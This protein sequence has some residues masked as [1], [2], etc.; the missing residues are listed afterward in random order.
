MARTMEEDV[1]RLARK[2]LDR[3]PADS[4]GEKKACKGGSGQ[5]TKIDLQPTT[6][7]TKMMSG[8]SQLQKTREQSPEEERGEEDHEEGNNQDEGRRDQ[9][10][11]TTGE[12]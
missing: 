4:G 1:K 2:T 3:E 9:N 8:K 6:I 7:E 5:T 10:V 11:N 12:R